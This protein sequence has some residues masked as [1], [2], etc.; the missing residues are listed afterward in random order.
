MSLLTP[1][2]SPPPKGRR[3][4]CP[5][6]RRRLPPKAPNSTPIL[7]TS[8]SIEL[9]G[10]A[11]CPDAAKVVTVFGKTAVLCGGSVPRRVVHIGPAGESELVL[12]HLA[13]GMYDALSQLDEIAALIA[14]AQG[15]GFFVSDSV[16]SLELTR[17]GLPSRA[18]GG[19]TYR[20]MILD[21]LEL[22]FLLIDKHCD[23]GI[24]LETDGH[25]LTSSVLLRDEQ[26]A[27]R[28]EEQ[29]QSKGGKGGLHRVLFVEWMGT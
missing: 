23:G 15:G 26:E 9:G 22:V 28:A 1:P 7:R 6:R 17:V 29:A 13:E 5:R 3:H 27:T 11:A 14:A 16:R 19:S 12:A 24:I 25:K 18:V 4:P 20:N 10:I 2:C 21:N 8:A